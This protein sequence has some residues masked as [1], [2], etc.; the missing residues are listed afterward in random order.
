M[1]VKEDGVYMKIKDA[2]ASLVF[3]YFVV[4]AA[5]GLLFSGFIEETGMNPFLL[6]TIFFIPILIG[7]LSAADKEQRIMTHGK[8]L[9]FR[10]ELYDAMR[11][12]SKKAE[13]YQNV[14]YGEF[15]DQWMK[16]NLY[17]EMIDEFSEKIYDEMTKAEVIGILERNIYPETPDVKVFYGA[18]E[19][20]SL[21]AGIDYY[22][23]I[24]KNGGRIK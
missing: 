23:I 1:E 22:D 14:K 4:W 7:G 16:D 3:I 15:M 2:L 6:T 24:N 20:L 21:C 5:T 19:I 18:I 10:H 11:D 9:K 13:T 12:V 8:Y 17:P